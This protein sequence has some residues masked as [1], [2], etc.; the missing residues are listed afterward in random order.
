MYPILQYAQTICN[1]NPELKSFCQFNSN[2]TNDNLEPA[3]TT[4]S[5]LISETYFKGSAE[6]FPII[7]AVKK[8]V[9]EANWR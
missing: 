4:A 1:D 5:S 2:G 8:H 7:A 9:G 3:T 6:T